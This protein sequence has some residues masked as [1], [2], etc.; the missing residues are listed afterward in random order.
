MPARF[1]FVWSK[2]T[3]LQ[4]RWR[5]G[6]ALQYRS[7]T[8]AA[9][10]RSVG[11]TYGR[12][13]VRSRPENVR[14]RLGYASTPRAPRTVNYAPSSCRWLSIRRSRSRANR[15][16]PAKIDCGSKCASAITSGSSPPVSHWL[17]QSEVSE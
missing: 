3:L 16:T 8:V 9:R 10:K 7:L 11:E 15:S 2:D 14:S 13:N 6:P 12:G 1:Y 5:V 4:I 17:S